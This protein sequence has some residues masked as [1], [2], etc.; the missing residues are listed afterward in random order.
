MALLPGAP[1]PLLFLQLP[2]TSCLRTLAVPQLP[3]TLQHTLL[4]GRTRRMAQLAEPTTTQKV[5]LSCTL[6]FPTTCQ[7]RAHGAG[8]AAFVTPALTLLLPWPPATPSPTPILTSS[9]LRALPVLAGLHLPLLSTGRSVFSLLFGGQVSQSRRQLSVPGGE[10]ALPSGSLSSANGEMK[11]WAEPAGFY[12]E[13]GPPAGFSQEC[14][15]RTRPQ[16][17]A[18]LIR[19]G[20]LE[21]FCLLPGS[22]HSLSSN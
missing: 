22:C 14:L 17:Q 1:H 15:L 18:T 12:R 16:R 4:R 5:C 3:G 19:L 7:I 10:E 20:G 6:G 8:A 13:A 11:G 2:K 21:G 9:S